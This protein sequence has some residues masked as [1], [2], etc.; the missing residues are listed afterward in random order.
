MRHKKDE[1]ACSHG[2]GQDPLLEGE[3]SVLVDGVGSDVLLD[4]RVLVVVDADAGVAGGGR[5]V[6]DHA[7]LAHRRLSLDQ[8]RQLAQGH[9][10]GDVLF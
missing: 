2:P 9:D 5:Q 8:N 4:V 1:P 3:V 10:P 6:R 7:G